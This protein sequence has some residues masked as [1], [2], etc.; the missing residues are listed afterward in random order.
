VPDPAP[1]KPATGSLFPGLDLTPTP[2]A[3]AKAK[4]PAK[5][6]RVRVYPRYC[7]VA[8]NRPVHTEFTYGVPPELVDEVVVGKRVAV[9]FGR[10]ADAR[11]Q[12]GVVVDVSERCAIDPAKVRPVTRVLDSEPV[13]DAELLGLTAWMAETYACAWGEALA[14]LLPAPMKREG[15]RRRVR[16][17]EL[18]AEPDLAALDELEAKHPKQFRLLRMLREVGGRMELVELLR[19]TNLSD[20]PAKSLERRGIVRID[21]VVPMSDPLWDDVPEVRPVHTNLSPGQAAAVTA[22]G[23]KLEA[24]EGTIFVLQGVTGSGKTEVYLQVIQ[25]ALDLGRGAIIVVP[26][27]ALTPQTVGWFRSRFG[28]VAVMHSRMTDVQ[29]LEMWQSVQSGRARVVVG[30]RS[31]LFAPVN[32]L[33]VVV[34]DEE[35]EPSF[36]QESSPRYHG[37]DVAVERARRSDAVCIL[38]SATPSL[39]TWHRART[40]DYQRLLLPDRVGGGR[41]PK[42][43]VVDMKLEKTPPG[44]SHLFSKH[45]QQELSAAIERGEQGILF[46]NRRGYAPVLWCPN[47]KEVV[48]C[49]QCDVSLTW[50]RSVDRVVCHSCCEEASPPKACPA[51]TAPGLR[52]LGSGAEQVEGAL[53]RVFPDARILRMDSDTMHRREDYERS[54]A[55][56][57]S[58]EVDLLVGTQMIAKGLDFPRVTVVGIVSADTSLHLP[59]FRASERTFQLISQV[60]GRAGRGELAGRIYVQTNSP[61]HPAIRRAAAHDFETFATEEFAL[62]EEL[63]YPPVGRLLRVVIEDEDERRANATAAACAETLRASIGEQ[64]VPI[65]GPAPAPMALLRGRHRRHILV[66]ASAALADGAFRAARRAA[67]EFAQAPSGSRVLVDVDPVSLF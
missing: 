28:E 12:V 53:R 40:G 39:E 33:G 26:E 38:G 35:H 47:C 21:H 46:L 30:A 7:A 57:G 59:D 8:L 43:E 66:K 16:F 67:V 36:K 37:R 9:G 56:F 1:K 19:K 22:M 25:A 24:R 31:A 52:M 42:V 51:C 5:P 55:A 54:L 20:A 18:L 10:G 60:A 58:G 3:P 50:H 48:R 44:G 62:R 29:R 64:M 61:D 6:R 41:M 14:A 49:D 2:K 63:G 17:L 45:L 15:R 23:A 27:I 13:I 11:R 34:V 65:L 4:A 32:D